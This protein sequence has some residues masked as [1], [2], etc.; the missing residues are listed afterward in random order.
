MITNYK[1]TGDTVKEYDIMT[2][3]R[4]A[5]QYIYVPMLL[6]SSNI[7]QKCATGDVVCCNLSGYLEDFL[8]YFSTLMR[9]GNI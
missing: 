9:D 4:E 8:K 5:K 6:E 2:V 1:K 3:H 7:L